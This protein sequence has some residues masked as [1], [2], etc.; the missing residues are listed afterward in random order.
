MT[1]PGLGLP[2]GTQTDL[3]VSSLGQ[4]G[5]HGVIMAG[6][7]MNI[8]LRP[9]VPHPHRRVTSPSHKHVDGWVKRE[10][11]NSTEMPV[12]VPD[13]LHVRSMSVLHSA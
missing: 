1:G 11:E 9:D 7:H 2:G 6:E 8:D 12:V 4:Q 10:T 5:C 13:D 3:G